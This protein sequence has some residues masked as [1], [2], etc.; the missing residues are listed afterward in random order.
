MS[1][2]YSRSFFFLLFSFG[3]IHCS[4]PQY[5]YAN[6]GSNGDSFI[7]NKG[8]WDKSVLYLAKCSGYNAWITK[9]GVVF[10][11][12]Q[13][14]EQLP[15]A[16]EQ[17][18]DSMRKLLG[19]FSLGKSRRHSIEMKWDGAAIIEQTVPLQPNSA[20][21]NYY[22]GNDPK[23]WAENVKLYSEVI[24]KNVWQG[25]DIRLYFQRHNLRYDFNVAA[26]AE[27][28]SIKL[29]F[30]GAQS[31]EIDKNTLRLGTQM[32][33]VVH[34]G[35][36]AFQDKS[37]KRNE[38]DCRFIRVNDKKVGIQVQ[39]QNPDASLII[40]P[41]VYQ[42][43]LGGNGKETPCDMKI[44][45][46]T[47][48]V[49]GTT[50]SFN[51]PVTMGSSTLNTPSDVFVS[52]LSRDGRT[53]LW[54][55]Y[56]G[57]LSSSPI[58]EYGWKLLVADNIIYC[59]GMGGTS[60]PITGGAYD[61]TN[62]VSGASVIGDGFFLQ[63]SAGGGLNSSTFIGGPSGVG[64]PFGL[65]IERDAS[66]IPI[67]N[68]NVVIAGITPQNSGM[69]PLGASVGTTTYQ[70]GVTDYFVLKMNNA[71]T[72]RLW[73]TY[74]GGF[75]S[76]GNFSGG[77]VG[78]FPHMVSVMCLPNGNIVFAGSGTTSAN[79]PSTGNAHGGG[80]D[81]Y[82]AILPS[83]GSSIIAST[84]YGGSAHEAVQ[85]LDYDN[86]GNIFITGTTSSSGF[87]MPAGGY[88]NTFTGSST[89]AFILKFSPA[90]SVVSGT[91]L[92]GQS[93]KGFDIAVAKN[94]GDVLFC[95]GTA[96]P[97][98][99]T[100]ILKP[101]APSRETGVVAKLNNTLSVLQYG[102]YNTTNDIYNIEATNTGERFWI[103][104]FA[105][106]SMLVTPS[107]YDSDP[108][109]ST[110]NFIAF[111]CTDS[112]YAAMAG[113]SKNICLGEF[114]E[115]GKDPIAGATYIW[116]PSTNVTNTSAS[117][118]EV[119]PLVTT[120]YTVTVRD[121]GNCPVVDTVTIFVYPKPLVPI[122]SILPDQCVHSKAKYR[123]PRTYTS[124]HT[125]EWSIQGGTILGS[126]QGQEVEVE[127]TTAGQGILNIKVKS[128]ANCTSD[129]RLLV[130]VHPA[131]TVNVTPDSKFICYGSSVELKSEVMGGT[132]VPSSFT[133][134][135]TPAIG[136]SSA[137]VASPIAT[138]QVSTVYK[139]TVTDSKGCSSVDSAIINVNQ[140]L[141]V[142]AGADQTICFGNEVTISAAPF[143]G[144][145][146]YKYEW[147]ENNVLLPNEKSAVLK[148]KP[149]STVQYIITLSDIFDCIARDTVLVTVNPEIKV[150]AGEDIVLCLSG[151]KK[152]EAIATGLPPLTYSWQPT[153]GL[154]DPTSLAPTFSGSTPSITKYTLTVT[155]NKGCTSTDDVQITVG[156]PPVLSAAQDFDFGILYGCEEKTELEFELE[157][158]GTGPLAITTPIISTS[159][160][161]FISS[162]IPLN[163]IPVGTKLKI[164]MRYAPQN[165]GVHNAVLTL[166][167]E[168]CTQQKTI[169]LKGEKRGII[170]T[171]PDSINVG[172]IDMCNLPY[173]EAKLP[174]SYVGSEA[175]SF[176]AVSTIAG[177]SS[178]DIQI[179]TPINIGDNEF[180]VRLTPDASLNDGYVFGFLEVTIDPC[181]T[182]K[183]IKIIG[184]KV[185]TKLI[186]VNS[187]LNFGFVK[188]TQKKTLS[189][190]FK[191]TGSKDITINP[192][193][194]SGIAPPF[195]ILSTNPQLPVVLKPNDELE[196]IVEYT[197]GTLG[198][199]GDQ[200]E[201]N[202]KIPCLISATIDMEGTSTN[203]PVPSL[204]A[205]PLVFS[206][207]LKISETLT[208][209][210]IVTNN[211]DIPVEVK[212]ANFVSNQ[213]NVF[214]V[215]PFAPKTIQP[216]ETMPIPIRFAPL[217]GTPDGLKTGN[218]RVIGDLASADCIVKGTVVSD[219]IGELMIDG[220]NFPSVLLTES[221]NQ[222]INISTTSPSEDIISVA[223]TAGDIGDFSVLSYPPTVQ[224]NGS[225]TV[226]VRF[227]PTQTG[228]RQATITAKTK[229]GLTATNTLTGIGSLSSA[230][231]VV[232]D[233]FGYP[234]E[235]V[236]LPIKIKNAT[237]IALSGA[238]EFNVRLYMNSTVL[239]F[240]DTN[241]TSTINGYVRSAK[242]TLPAESPTNDDVL[243]YIP[244]RVLFGNEEISSIWL[245]PLDAGGA[246]VK[247]TAEQGSLTMLGIRDIG[248]KRLFDPYAI[249]TEPIVSP[250]P[251]DDMV[252]IN[253]TIAESGHHSL[254]VVSLT[255]ETLATIL[256]DEME[257][258]D[259][260]V[261]F[262]VKGLSSGTYRIIIHTPTL[263]EITP[264]IVIH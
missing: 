104:G 54:S 118:T 130:T 90:L 174:I 193:D 223:I 100:A 88:D 157:N 153:T 109:G 167:Y 146:D 96:D 126:N 68:G 257:R 74:I 216:N 51:F 89:N 148:T 10:D 202:A 243:A 22:I 91:F 124:G 2:W 163:N 27:P 200:I 176:I 48:V 255:G 246:S 86:L 135:W 169:S 57:S 161:T 219:F 162:D 159:D 20:Y 199:Q 73:S 28:E 108:N 225:K 53:L 59:V 38:I 192:L 132:G 34:D 170:L 238:K 31:V 253:F 116:Q 166:N 196:V 129:G 172:D 145:P 186:A 45:D 239:D 180:T 102:S 19:L 112:A 259:Y 75:S 198:E 232:G 97:T 158:K 55:T 150:N 131:V 185:S 94:T 107:V 98:T 152:I 250:N 1:I 209:D 117:K 138:P 69:T 60:F 218:L 105:H 227:T 215:M 160:F 177:V 179:G 173:A 175:G 249:T 137:I 188:Q 140:S 226:Q 49:T 106:P 217:T 12:F 80:E 18:P 211:G 229:S 184:N 190:Y 9:T 6:S 15:S 101:H 114:A 201:I 120:K 205:A 84:Y 37:G 52:R 208:E 197:A 262:S 204:S 125:Y 42:T 8:Q 171:I 139:L 187:P 103:N 81:I 47:A 95:G 32:G 25:I 242:I 264:F 237:Q 144:S 252:S 85:G 62:S 220:Y 67:P 99:F 29:A 189:G 21:H 149:N 182:K 224:A 26:T 213:N 178:T 123:L 151:T 64:H 115:I 168:P 203:D 141:K 263:K 5:S 165:Q 147:R 92:G 58:S 155:D 17:K 82:L 3:L 44:L 207:A 241:S 247:L 231:L 72:S 46:E 248:G 164:K 13:R 36:T 254:T 111:I 87:S 256:E 33:T 7:E 35:L 41:Y 77:L 128:P 23:K 16:A 66:G 133:Y 143:G 183:T 110:D 233:I 195:A 210:V 122:D 119:N 4:T 191:N 236:Q 14:I 78:N 63:L 113:S 83:N 235:I 261:P 260:T 230:V 222:N 142:T 71:G 70:G 24:L 194:I 93:T 212:S 11:Y 121:G 61:N 65:D 240:A 40:D 127:W 156:G 181:A 154:D 30:K 76:E 136:L 244:C 79:I 39:K 56:I 221:L 214:T 234:G 258:G 245:K 251:S 206:Q 134:R 228:N 43:F 50:E